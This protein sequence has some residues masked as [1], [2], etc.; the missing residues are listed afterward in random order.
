LA[1]FRLQK[2]AR[3][4]RVTLDEY[5]HTLSDRRSAVIYIH[6]N[7]ISNEVAIDRGFD[8]HQRINCS[9][10]RPID[11]VIWSWPSEKEG[12]LTHD[13][14]IKA[15]RTDGQGLYLGWLLRRHFEHDIRTTL[16]AYSFGGRI[17]T[18]A[19]HAVAGGELAG[20]KLSGEPV[21][22]AP[23]AAGLVAPAVDSHWLTDHGYHR[24]ATQN[25]D[26]LVLMYNRRDAVLKRYWLIDRVRG[27][28]AMGYVGPTKFAA[29][30]DGSRLPVRSRDCSPTIGF[31]HDE[32]DYYHKSC[33]AGSEMAR[34]IDELHA[35]H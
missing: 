4:T 2:C 33:N 15:A 30:H 1:I 23:F 12:M 21:V 5:L 18:G 31:Q 8:I 13:A 29:R 35:N 9:R 3:P 22:G 20:Q 14:R 24:L 26:R 32:L 28:M 19:L 6:G 10:A 27:R 25:L 17:V 7:R 16:V 11:W 34:L